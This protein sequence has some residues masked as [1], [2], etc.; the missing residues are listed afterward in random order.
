MVQGCYSAIAKKITLSP[1][2]IPTPKGRFFAVSLITTVYINRYLF[3]EGC[4]FMKKLYKEYVNF[5]F[6]SSC[7]ET[8]EFKSFATKLKRRLSKA[9]QEEHLELAKF[10]KGHFECSGF[11]YNPESQ[12]YAYFIVGDVRFD[13]MGKKPLDVCLIRTAEH[14][15]DY[16]GGHNNFCRVN[17][18]PKKLKALTV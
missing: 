17:E 8:P 12:K 5:H 15:K 10:S 13:M 14:D 16:H 18:M 7:C 6:E 3:K 9:V 2:F 4:C 1:Q 11:I